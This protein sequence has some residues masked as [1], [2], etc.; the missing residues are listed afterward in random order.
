MITGYSAGE[1]VKF[2]KPGAK[3]ARIAGGQRH[4]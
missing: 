1:R 4:F 2:V 3:V